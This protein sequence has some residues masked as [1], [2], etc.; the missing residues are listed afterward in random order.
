MHQKPA[1]LIVEDDPHISLLI[2]L[3]LED[4]GYVVTHVD[5]GGA[6][7]D[8]MSRHTFDLVILDWML[9]DVQGVHVCRIIK[10][11]SSATFLPILMLTARGEPADRVAGLD[12]GADDYL[13][14]PFDTEEL[15]ARVRALLRIR[16]AELERSEALEAL[17]RQHAELQQAYD[18]L[19]A[20]QVQLVQAS[21][22][23]SLGT[24]VA[25]VAH[26]LNNPLAIILGSAELL[27]QQD[28][29]EDRSAV[30]QIIAGAKRARRVVRSLAAFAQHGGMQHAWH[31]VPDLIENVLDVRRES[32]RAAGIAL[33]VRCAPQLPKLWLDGAQFQQALL[34]LLL[35]A[36]RALEQHANPQLLIAVFIGCMRAGAPPLFA[37]HTLEQTQG[38]PALLIDIADNGPGLP[39]EVRERLFEPF[40]TTQPVGSG[41]GLGLATTYGIVAHHAGRMQ[42]S[43]ALGVG[44]TFRIILPYYP[45]EQPDNL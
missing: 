27:P 19:R 13:I 39:D 5:A 11:K 38:E 45:A 40:V 8:L 30:T 35:N 36:E 31:S 16:V 29:E 15:L 9:P 4:A 26:E 23:A 17:A 37:T 12:A 21:K 43:T 6:A 32:L 20:T 33:E 3:L 34:N 1:L 22:M 2:K 10:R 25:G 18:Q 7:L 44:T 14:K 28:S 41:A 24:L 42:V